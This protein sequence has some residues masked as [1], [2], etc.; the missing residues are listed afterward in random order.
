[1]QTISAGRYSY[2]TDTGTAAWMA[3]ISEGGDRKK[4][5]ERGERN[6][7]K[8]LRSQCKDELT[9]RKR[10]A[11]LAG[12]HYEPVQVNEKEPVRKIHYRISIGMVKV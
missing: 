10:M 2:T 4:I 11:S 1:M 5:R 6:R 8:K 3:G 9:G 12:G 7:Q